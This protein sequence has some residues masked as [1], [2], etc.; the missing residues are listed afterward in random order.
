ME[1]KTNLKYII[2]VEGNTEKFY[3]QHLQKLINESPDAKC[4]VSIKCE[5]SQK[6]TSAYKKLNNIGK[7]VVCHVC[8][9]ES[10]ISEHQKKFQGTIEELSNAT[11]IPGIKKAELYYTNFTFELWL[12]LHKDDCFNVYSHR[13]QYLKPLNSAYKTEFENLNKFKAENNVKKCLDKITLP[14][15][16]KAIKR[17]KKIM[18]DRKEYSQP[19]HLKNKKFE[20]VYYEDNPSLNIHILIENILTACGIE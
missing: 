9:V 8:D 19:K 17:A 10:N 7:I 11:K 20:I 15:I 13:S 12:I 5:V 4:T 1:K 18:E 3:F 6:P 16:L 2:T 14:D